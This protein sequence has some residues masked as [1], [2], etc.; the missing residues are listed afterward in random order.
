MAALQ[1]RCAPLASGRTDQKAQY[2]QEAQPFAD[3]LGNRK[4]LRAGV[5]CPT[6]PGGAHGPAVSSPS[7]GRRSAEGAAPQAQA[8][9]GSLTAYQMAGIL[10]F[11][12]DFSRLVH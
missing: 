2:E 7:R 4:A 9:A 11:S 12:L 10:V 6:A 8:L 5:V 3:D 1:P